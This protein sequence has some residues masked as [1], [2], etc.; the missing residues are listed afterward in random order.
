[1]N[2]L[3]IE[4][5]YSGSHKTWLDQ[6]V[7]H[8][9]HHIETLT[10]SGKYWKWRMYGAAHSMAN[11]FMEQA[12][13]G[14]YD[15]LDLI[16]VSDM[17]DLSNFLSLVYPTLSQLKPIKVGI[18]FHE[19]QLAYP[20]QD[21]SEDIKKNRDLHY[22]MMNYYSIL[23]ADFV[24]FN[25]SY[26]MN[27]FYEEL[28]LILKSM[29]DYKHKT[30]DACRRKSQVLPIGINLPEPP[31]DDYMATHNPSTN[32]P[33]IL[34]NHRLEH[35]KNPDGFLDLMIRLVHEGY[36]YRLAFLGEMNKSAK[37]KY[38][39]KLNQ[40]K[41]VLIVEGFLPYSDY[42]YWLYRADI[43]PVTSNHDFFGISVMEGIGCHCYPL[44]PH[45]LTYPKLYDSDANPEIFY[46]TPEELHKKLTKLLIDIETRK[47]ESL[48]VSDSEPYTTFSQYAQPYQWKTMITRYDRVFQELI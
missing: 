8:S 23:S 14:H 9:S 43:M 44:L 24:L 21:D 11:E 4:P 13:L 38:Q 46:K 29:P 47:K 19:N 39:G 28:D 33:V 48:P 6:V 34:W 42:V 32:L 40:L 37:K 27:S 26:N 25:S 12:S 31:S 45:R 22:G 36:Q 35:D 3:F 15:N 20:W 41:D 17:L 2:I 18:Y 1:M 16:I 5:F 30:I 10:M 7:K